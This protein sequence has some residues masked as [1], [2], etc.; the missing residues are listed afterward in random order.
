MV[1][2]YAAEVAHSPLKVNLVEPGLLATHMRAA[3][4]P[5]EDASLLPRPEAIAPVF[6]ELAGADCTQSGQRRQL[7]G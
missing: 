5:A 6:V 1:L 4:F 7:G 2:A 3:A